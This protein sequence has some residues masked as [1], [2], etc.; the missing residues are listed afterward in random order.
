[1]FWLEQPTVLL[2]NVNPIP[3]RTMTMDERL[4]ALTWLVIF[5][6][7]G[8]YLLQ[9]TYWWLVLILGLGLVIFAYA[10]TTPPPTVAHYTCRNPIPVTP[11]TKMRI[12]PR[13]S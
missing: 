7:L 4:N 13:S 6:S 8:L 10:L 1:M 9:L 3:Q 12:R 11:A 2:R 5:I